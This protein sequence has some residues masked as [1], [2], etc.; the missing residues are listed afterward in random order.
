MERYNTEYPLGDMYES[1]CVY[2]LDGAEHVIFEGATKLPIGEGTD[3][4]TEVYD[5]WADCLQEI[6]DLLSDASWYINVDD[7]D[8]TPYFNC[9]K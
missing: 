8:V 6:I 4:F 7:A 2:D 9:P 1:F 5:Y 3:H